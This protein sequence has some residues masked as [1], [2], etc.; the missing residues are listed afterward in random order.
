MFRKL[1]DLYHAHERAEFYKARAEAAEARLFA[2]IDSNRLR[3]DELL[4]HFLLTV[5]TSSQQVRLPGKRQG[6][7]PAAS[8]AAAVQPDDKIDPLDTAAQIERLARLRVEE[9]VEAAE[10]AGRPYS[11]SE[12]EQLLHALLADPTQ[13]DIYAN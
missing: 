12:K 1:V 6:L 11:E 13:Y 4:N 7:A 5:A 8:P 2:E 10:L 9:F 3:E